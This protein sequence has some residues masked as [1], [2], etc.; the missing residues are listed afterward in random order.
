MG[1]VVLLSKQDG[2]SAWTGGTP[3]ADWSGLDQSATDE[4]T[5]PNQLRPVNASSSQKGYNYRRTGMTTAFTQSNSL[6]DF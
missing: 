3:L 2:W 1:D 6:V 5:S 4:L